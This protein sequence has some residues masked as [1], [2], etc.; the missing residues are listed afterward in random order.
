MPMRLMIIITINTTKI[1]FC[2]ELSHPFYYRFDTAN[3]IIVEME[4]CRNLRKI[5]NALLFD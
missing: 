1:G 2:R 3:A 5:L 4:S